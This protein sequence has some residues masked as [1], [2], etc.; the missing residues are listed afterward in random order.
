MRGF[1]KK[2]TEGWRWV[3]YKWISGKTEIEIDAAIKHLENQ[4]LSDIDKAVAAVRKD[5]EEGTLPSVAQVFAT[6]E[7]YQV[8]NGYDKNGELVMENV[9]LR[10]SGPGLIAGRAAF[11]VLAQTRKCMGRSARKR[12]KLSDTRSEEPASSATYQTYLLKV[13]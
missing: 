3:Q 2:T 7:F 9:A 8:V 13:L 1:W 4:D 10:G 11:D 6:S 5:M 12:Q